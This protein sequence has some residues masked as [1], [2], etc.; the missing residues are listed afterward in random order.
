MTVTHILYDENIEHLWDE[1]EDSA[2]DTDHTYFA[3]W[4]HDVKIPYADDIV[5]DNNI[6]GVTITFKDEKDLTYFLLTL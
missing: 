5:R 2:G 4:L 6:P 1:Y 3:C